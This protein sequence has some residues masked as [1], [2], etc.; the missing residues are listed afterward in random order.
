[1][2]LRIR[3]LMILMSLAALLLL[4]LQGYWLTSLYDN[5]QQRL[6]QQVQD[7]LLK[8][9]EQALGT[10]VLSVFSGPD[11][12][13][14]VRPYLQPAGVEEISMRFFADSL[15][16][17]RKG[18]LQLGGAASA[19]NLQ[20]YDSL[21][22]QALAEYGLGPAA[23]GFWDGIQQRYVL[24]GDPWALPQVQTLQLQA[25]MPHLGMRNG[26]Q[27]FLPDPFW[28]LLAGMWVPLA[29]SALLFLSIAS[30]FG[31][32]LW[33][34]LRQK[35]LSEM[36]S[37]FINNM[38]HEF[39]TPLST[40][41]LAIEAL[42]RFEVRKQ[43]EQALL[44][45]QI[46][47]EETGRLGNLVEQVLQAAVAERQGL[48]LQRENLLPESL[49]AEAA[50]KA[51]LHIEEAGGQLQIE[52]S[53]LTT[54]VLA[55]ATHLRNLLD[56]LLD[57]A[58]K[59]AGEAPPQVVLRRWQQEDA[60]YIQVQD[61][62]IGIPPQAQGHIFE[63]FYRVPTGALHD[64]RGFGL[65]LSYAAQVARQHGGNLQLQSREGQGSTFTLMLPLQPIPYA[66]S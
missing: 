1:M 14:V 8:A 61:R 40:I 17:G 43:E 39:K 31:Y 19:T 65:G 36:K 12:G 24:I 51:R 9:N 53:P 5:Q 30:C 27:L 60:I 37:D 54:E 56:N 45:L 16:S 10:A 35:K 34:L 2:L 38:T 3:L 11:G 32:A 21:L 47:Q 13:M 52:G 57:N 26:L 29:A 20:A 44:Y 48:Q 23:F 55:D 42:L 66:Q 7:A 41:S 25:H 46:A 28:R 50:E 62:G 63:A 15:D 6:Q 64:V 49:L 18:M 58:C 33:L 22:Q 59:Y 4:G